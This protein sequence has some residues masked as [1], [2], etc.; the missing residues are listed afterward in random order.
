MAKNPPAARPRRRLLRIW[1]PLLLLAL[2]VG[3]CWWYLSDAYTAD[4]AAIA[5]FCADFSAQERSLEDGTLAFGTGQEP[6]GLIFYPG[7]KVDH[8]AYVPLARALA[9]KGVFCVVCP[10]PFRLAVLDR[11]AAL[12][13]RQAFPEVGCWYV[14][15]HSLGGVMAAR[16]LAAHPEKFDGLLLLGAYADKDL[17]GCGV[18]VLSV[19]GSEDGVMNRSAYSECRGNLPG[20]AEELVLEGGCHAGF[21]MYGP[22]RGDGTPQISAAEQIQKTAQAVW[23]WIGRRER[24]ADAEAA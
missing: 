20:D 23:D 21:G 1:L 7:G 24:G 3:A 8:R 17:S 5:A 18:P 4:E 16:C 19:Y 22:Q 10:M 6:V 11:D 14:G 9:E 15:G 13:A 12:E 2:L